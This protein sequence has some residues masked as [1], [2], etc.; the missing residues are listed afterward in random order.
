MTAQLK[1]TLVDYDPGT[2]RMRSTPRHVYLELSSRCNLACVH[3]PKDFGSEF[4]H[5]QLDMPIEVVEAVAPWLQEATFINLNSIGESL[6]SPHFDATIGICGE[7]SAELSFNTNGLLLS[8][9][10]CRRIVDAGVHSVT[11]SMDGL[12][13]NQPIRGVGYETVRQRLLT[14]AEAK[15]RAGTETPHLA[16]AFTLMRRNAA[17][18]P[19]LLRDLLPRVRLHAI[20]VQP[21]I[22]YYEALRNENPFRDSG[23]EQSIEEARAISTAAGTQFVYYRSQS[24]GDERN[25]DDAQGQMGQFSERYGCVDPFYEVKIRSTGEL[26]ACSYGLMSEVRVQDAPLDEIWNHSWYRALR[27]RLHSGVF[28]GRCKTCPYVWGSATHQEDPVRVGVHHS[29]EARFFAGYR[30]D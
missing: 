20:H 10:R 19:E 1:E 15:R 16:V 28:E 4:D 9:N 3:C 23:P 18:L 17:E 12:Q 2:G 7:G 30:S 21:L 25:R 13:S 26:M 27:Q 5:P 22:V 24:D 14:L 11:V 8:E 6:L 29:Q